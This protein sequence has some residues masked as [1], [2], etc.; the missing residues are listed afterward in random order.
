M[1]RMASAVKRLFP[2]AVSTEDERMVCS[3]RE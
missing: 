3:Q 1:I 2:C